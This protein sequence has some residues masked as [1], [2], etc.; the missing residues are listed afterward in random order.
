MLRATVT[1]WDRTS[2]T[3]MEANRVLTRLGFNCCRIGHRLD[4]ADQEGLS[5]VDRRLSAVESALASGFRMDRQG[6]GAYVKKCL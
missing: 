2:F 6:A 4:G 1:G 3:T 5:P